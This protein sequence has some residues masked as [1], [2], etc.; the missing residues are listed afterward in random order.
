[1]GIASSGTADSRITASVART[2][3]RMATTTARPLGAAPAATQLASHVARGTQGER[4]IPAREFFLDFL[5]TALQPDEILTEVQV[6]L[7]TEGHG[8]SYQK[9]A[10]QASGYAIVGVGAIPRV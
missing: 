7:P 5:T 2:A 6:P 10:N 9:L 1:M 3:T 4:R 8:W